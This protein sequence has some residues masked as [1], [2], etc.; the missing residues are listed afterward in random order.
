[1]TKWSDA[2][3]LYE[4]LLTGATGPLKKYKFAADLSKGFLRL[5]LDSKIGVQ[6]LRPSEL[7]LPGKGTT[8]ALERTRLIL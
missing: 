3:P 4:I 7:F 5:N 6:L 2:R 8:F 1:M